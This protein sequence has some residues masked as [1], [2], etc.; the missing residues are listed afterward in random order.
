MSA[1]VLI[2]DDALFMRNMLKD[3]LMAGGY[4]VVGEAEKGAEAVEKYQ[5]LK[6][7]L[8]TMDIVMKEGSSSGI[9]A[10]RQILKIDARAAVIMCSGLGQESQV[11]EA[12]EAGALDFVVKPFRAEE[13]LAVVKKVLGK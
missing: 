10:T 13:V 4:D 3:I 2:V 12:I 11:M 7:D 6:P 1:R 5:A 8:V 9:D